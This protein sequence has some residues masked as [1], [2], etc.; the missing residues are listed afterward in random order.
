MKS[1]AIKR[2]RSLDG[3]IATAVES[4]RKSRTAMF[5]AL[6]MVLVEACGGGGGTTTPDSSGQGTSWSNAP[7][8]TIFAHPRPQEYVSVGAVTTDAG[9]GYGPI[10][11]DARIHSIFFDAASQPKIRYNAAS[12]YELQIPGMA[13]DR[14]IHYKALSNPSPDNNFFQPSGVD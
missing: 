2:L 1:C 6:A 8:V 13:Y 14:L 3:T 11:K 4:G 12:Y 5:A 10:S 9:G 7:P